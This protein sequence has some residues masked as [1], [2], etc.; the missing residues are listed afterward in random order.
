MRKISSLA[1]ILAL[2]LSAHADPGDLTFCHFGP[3][4]KV[5]DPVVT[6]NDSCAGTAKI[7]GVLWECAPSSQVGERV[8]KFHSQL[9]DQAKGACEEH[10]ANRAPHCKGALVFTSRC[11]LRTTE[12]DALI[13]GKRFG[14]RTDC[15]GGAFAYCSIFD[16]GFRTGDARD[17]ASQ[18]PNCRCSSS[19]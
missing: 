14:C 13:V 10:C 8:R 15:A 17:L 9:L 5:I 3:K 16:A 11:G 7:Q 18:S 19:R 6:G 12:D 1:L 2:A 4:L